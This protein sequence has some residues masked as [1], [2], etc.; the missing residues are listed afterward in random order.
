M[1]TEQ[2]RADFVSKLRDD[3]PVPC[4]FQVGDQVTFTNEYGV[5]FPGL[6][7]TGFAEDS[8]FYGRFVYLDTDSYWFPVRPD[9]LKLERRSL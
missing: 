4:D 8:E 5:A 2:G 3:P 9:E 7:V 6:T 1:T